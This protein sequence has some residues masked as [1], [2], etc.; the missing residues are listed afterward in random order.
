[1]GI[2]IQWHINIPIIQ[3]HNGLYSIKLTDQNKCVAVGLNWEVNYPINT[4][5]LLLSSSIQFQLSNDT[6]NSSSQRQHSL[7]LHHHHH[8]HVG[9]YGRVVHSG[10]ERWSETAHEGVQGQR[11][12]DRRKE[13]NRG[14]S[15]APILDP[16][17]LSSSAQRDGQR[18]SRERSQRCHFR[19]QRRREVHRKSLPHRIPGNQRRYCRLQMGLRIPFHPKDHLGR[20]FS[21]SNLFFFF[22]LSLSFF[23]IC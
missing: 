1:M 12:R 7:Y 21:R 15:G 5:Q 11:R 3:S 16:R 9:L 10:D 22:L 20:F 18:V 19:L 2:N 6:P 13:R 14:G 17:W 4:N 23:W 8:H